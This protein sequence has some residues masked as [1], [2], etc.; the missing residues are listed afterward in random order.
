MSDAG[1]NISRVLAARDPVALRVGLIA[2]TLAF[3]G[4]FLV[5]PLGVVATE[6]FRKGFGAYVMALADPEARSAILLTLTIAAI[7]LYNPLVLLALLG[8]VVCAAVRTSIFRVSP[9]VPG[10][11]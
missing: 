6:A 7:V 4:L 1:L 3:L 2:L 8:A 9:L 5:A 10:R 11:A